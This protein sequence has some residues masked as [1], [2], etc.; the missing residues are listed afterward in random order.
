M[1]QCRRLF[2][3]L[4]WEVIVDLHFTDREQFPTSMA[5]VKSN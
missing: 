5:L 1:G 2:D 3:D 4:L